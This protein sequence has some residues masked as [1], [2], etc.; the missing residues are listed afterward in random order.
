MST[1]KR[2]LCAPD[3]QGSTSIATS[4]NVYIVKEERHEIAGTVYRVLAIDTPA[5][6]VV[7]AAPDFGWSAGGFARHP[8]MTA[9]WFR[10]H[11]G[12][13]VRPGDRRNLADALLSCHRAHTTRPR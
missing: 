13:T 9:E 3:S 6:D 2:A 1:E 7:M 11:L 5:G 4:D 8:N 12:R 10:D